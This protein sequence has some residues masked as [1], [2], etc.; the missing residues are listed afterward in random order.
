[1]V[2]QALARNRKTLRAGRV[3]LFLATVSRLPFEE[4]SIDR[5]CA[6]NSFQFWPAPA[7]DLR[8][9]RRVL[10][11]GGLIALTLRQGAGTGA[12]GMGH[13]AE[14]SRVPEALRTLAAADFREPRVE[15]RRLRYVTAACVLARA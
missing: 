4:A 8:E 14:P 7:A 13:L 6:V 11:P 3:A 10:K 9:L 2:R 5:A 12:F 1:M 15:S